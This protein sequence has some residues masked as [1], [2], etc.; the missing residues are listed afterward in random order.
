MGHVPQTGA[1]VWYT[2]A[3]DVVWCTM[4]LDVQN[5]CPT[6]RMLKVG[7]VGPP[8]LGPRVVAN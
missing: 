8:G 7:S 3:L 4:A 2:M 5:P 1:F 6:A